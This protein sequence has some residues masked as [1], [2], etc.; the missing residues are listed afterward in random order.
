MIITSNLIW[1]I[2][3]QV[4]TKIHEKC[5]VNLIKIDELDFTYSSF[6]LEIVE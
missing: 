4:Q 5:N 6:E 2:I 3:E 1:N